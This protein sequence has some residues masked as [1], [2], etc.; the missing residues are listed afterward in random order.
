MTG[1][2]L[3]SRAN[4]SAT[5]AALRAEAPGRAGRVAQA[6]RVI[7]RSSEAGVERP[8]AAIRARGDKVQLYTAA[9]LKVMA[10]AMIAPWLAGA[11]ESPDR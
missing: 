9:Q 10:D 11:S 7:G 4:E 5:S 1:R 3:L 6:T 8:K 2:R